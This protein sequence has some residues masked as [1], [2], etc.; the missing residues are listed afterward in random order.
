M[1]YTSHFPKQTCDTTCLQFKS[2]MKILWE[3]EK[4][5]TTTNFS[6]PYSVFYHFGELTVIFIK[7]KTKLSSANSFSLEGSNICHLEKGWIS[8]YTHF[9]YFCSYCYF[10]FAVILILLMQSLLFLLMQLLLLL[11]MKLLLAYFNSYCYFYFCSYYY[12]TFAAISILLLL[13]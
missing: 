11:L 7:L 8:Y 4:L 1:I 10:T 13:L 9:S 5:L 2:L 6:F 3:K 12:F